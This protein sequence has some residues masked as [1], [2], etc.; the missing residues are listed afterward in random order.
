MPHSLLLVLVL[1]AACAAP[2]QT[3]RDSEPQGWQR[4]L[5]VVYGLRNLQEEAD[6]EPVDE[7]QVVGLELDFYDPSAWYR[8]DRD[9]GYELGLFQSWDEGDVDVPGV[10]SIDVESQIT[11]LSLG[12]RLT[13][14]VF[15][16]RLHPYLGTGVS[17]LR[18]EAD[19]ASGSTGKADDDLGFG[20]YIRGGAYW[21]PTKILRLGFDY[22]WLLF[23]SV[24]VGVDTDVDYQQLALVVGFGF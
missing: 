7:Q 11:E 22:R 16:R 20:G 8:T 1:A 6:W 19:P 24:D 13:F 10:G 4:N 17:L 15:D 3:G 2:P 23:S 12:G 14:H 9:I 21:S 5:M 18:A